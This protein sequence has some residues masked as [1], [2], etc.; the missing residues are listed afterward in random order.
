MVYHRLAE[1]LERDNACL[2]IGVAADSLDNCGLVHTRGN[3]DDVASWLEYEILDIQGTNFFIADKVGERDIS[4][5]MNG[6]LG[7]AVWRKT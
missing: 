1:K 7:R 5:C 2:A 3:V 6:K 4:L